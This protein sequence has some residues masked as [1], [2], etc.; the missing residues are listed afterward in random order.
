MGKTYKRMPYGY[1][2]SMKGHRKCLAIRE[3][4][5]LEREEK[6]PNIRK[7]ALPPDPWD[8]FA[9]SREVWAPYGAAR[10]MKEEGMKPELAIKKLARKFHIPYLQAQEIFEK[11]W[12]R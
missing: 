11:T 8:D 2:R 1:F 9:F 6:I 4:V 3:E 12:I 7:R 5:K 10:R